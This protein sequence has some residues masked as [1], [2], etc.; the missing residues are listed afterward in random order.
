[1]KKKVAII[2]LVISVLYVAYWLVRPLWY[3]DLSYAHSAKIIYN[4]DGAEITANIKPEDFGELREML[5]GVKFKDTPSCSFGTDVSIVFWIPED[6]EV[7]LCPAC[8]GCPLMR[9]GESDYY[10]KIEEAERARFNAIVEKYGMVFPC[11]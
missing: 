11:I 8:D 6:R 1:M 5:R 4:Y 10:I 2:F 7:M 3:V 9:I